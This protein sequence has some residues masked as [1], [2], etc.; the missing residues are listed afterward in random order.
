MAKQDYLFRY[1]TIIRKLRSSGE[2]TFEEISSYLQRESEL[3][4]KPVRLLIRTF[5]RDLKEIEALFGIEILY[6]FTK[7][8]YYIAWDEHDDMNNRMI[9][10]FDFISSIRMA[11]D[12]GRFM[13]FE[14]RKARGTTHFHGL[15]HAIRNRILLEL[16]H[17]KFVDDQPLLRRVAPYALKESGGRWYL[18]ARDMADKRIKTFGLD[19]IKGFT[20][21]PGRFDYPDDFD[22]DRQ[23]RYSFGIMNPMDTRPEE[24][25]LS[26]DPE[27]GKYIKSYPIH[28]SQTIL[29]D[30]PQ[31]FRIRLHL[32]VTYDLIQEILSYG[33]RVIVIAPESL[34]KEISRIAGK[35]IVKYEG[36]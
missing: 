2:A 25:D 1:L 18:L 11:G 9:E 23:F 15:L 10:S 8:V 35:V 31:E 27:Q 17:Q 14:K 36:K 33:D 6:D 12:I 30:N 34:R 4:D 26:F 22:V 19:R 21:T 7:R 13:Y 29:A 32:W 24:I 28:E 5:Q 3:T 20:N 16:E